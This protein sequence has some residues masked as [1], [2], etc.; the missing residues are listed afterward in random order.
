[1]FAILQKVKPAE[2][3]DQT[4]SLKKSS[5]T[6]CNEAIISSAHKKNRVQPG[7]YSPFADYFVCRLLPLSRPISMGQPAA[8][9]SHYQRQGRTGYRD[10]D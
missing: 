1:M 5:P 8:P 4:P 2:H 7:F 6:A 10:Q 9:I 3:V